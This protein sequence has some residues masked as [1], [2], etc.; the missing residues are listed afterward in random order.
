M[1]PG[2]AA[3]SG[4]V[5]TLSTSASIIRSNIAQQ[6]LIAGLANIPPTEDQVDFIKRLM[7]FAKS[8]DATLIGRRPLTAEEDV[9]RMLIATN[10]AKKMAVDMRLVNEETYGDHPGN[11]VSVCCRNVAERYRESA[12]HKGTQIIF[13]DIGKLVTDFDTPR[14]EITFTHDW[15]DKQKPELFRKMN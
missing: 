4:I 7:A 8:G 13:S 10:Y 2:L 14:S 3:R 1:T 11:K 15:S 6:P 5:R 9:G 12:E